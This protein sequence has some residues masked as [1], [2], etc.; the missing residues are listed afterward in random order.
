M[1]IDK[2]GRNCFSFFFFFLSLLNERVERGTSVNENRIA[3]VD[4]TAF[5]IYSAISV[6]FAVEIASS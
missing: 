4:T 2:L 3:R 5:E 6:F 1:R